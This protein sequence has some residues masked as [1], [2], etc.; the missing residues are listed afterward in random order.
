MTLERL[1]FVV[2]F[3]SSFYYMFLGLLAYGNRSD[4]ES[5]DQGWTLSPLWALFPSAYNEKGKA[6]CVKGKVAFWFAMT[7]SVIWLVSKGL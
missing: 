3:I 5:K 6:Q 2:A 7:S 4:D 1:L